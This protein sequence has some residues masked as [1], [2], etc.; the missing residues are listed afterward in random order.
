[1]GVFGVIGFLIIAL[2]IA[3]IFYYG[4]GRRGP[5]GAF[6]AFLLILFF[7]GWAGS[8][9]IAPAGP[10]LWGY[11]WL[12]IIFWVFMVALIIAVATPSDRPVEYDET[13]SEPSTGEA[14]A[15]AALGLFFWILLALLVA[16]ILIGLL[17]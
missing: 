1:M 4:L 6:W 13:T 8:L 11:A 12:P 3:S 15:A 5:W 17:T 10:V 9:W 2:I 14:G 7:A 16:A